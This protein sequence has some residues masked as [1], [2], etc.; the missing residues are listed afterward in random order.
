MVSLKN[1]GGQFQV[2]FGWLFAIIV[3]GIILFLA[4]YMA[5]KIINSGEQEIDAKLGQEIGV[6]TN[7]LETSFQAG[8]AVPMTVPKESRI[9]TECAEEGNFGLQ[10][11]KV[12]QKNFGK[13]S[14]TN[15]QSVFANKYIFSENPAEG[16]KFFLFSKPFEFP[17]KVGNLIY[18]I[19]TEDEYCFV[20]APENVKEELDSLGKIKNMKYENCTLS[21][22]PEEQ[23]DICFTYSS[24]CEV[25][26]DY[27]SGMGYTEK[28]GSRVYFVDDSLMYASIF[29]P[30]VEYECQIKRLMK[31]AGI[32][33][34]LYTDK[35]N[36]IERKGC[37]S[38]LGPDLTIFRNKVLQLISSGNSGDLMSLKSIVDEI[39]D[40]NSNLNCRLW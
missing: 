30:S 19:S 33:A 22:N 7:P 34:E 29:S 3:G 5:V 1:K 23:T 28:N 17:F 12:S 38:N 35:G 11:I 27:S 26:V 14:E 2:S 13:W 16:R 24:L 39:K 10:Q 6:L 36:F 15:V 32:L 21:A 37:S 8:V 18:L 31:R 25:Y 20:N 9:Y 40:K 4:I